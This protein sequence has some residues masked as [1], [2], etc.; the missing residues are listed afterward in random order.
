MTLWKWSQTPATNATADST[1]NWAEGQSPSSVNDSARAMMA[2]AAKYRDDHSGALVTGGTDTAYTVSSNQGFDTLA[3]LGGQSFKIKFDSTNGSAPTLNIDSLGAKAIQSADGTAIGTGII[4]ADSIWDVTYDNSIP[5]FILN[6]SGSYQPVDADLTAI[7][8]L[9]SA[10]DKVPYATGSGTWALA[11]FTSAGRALLDDADADAQLAT[12]GA[13]DLAKKDTI[14]SAS[15]IDTAVK[16]SLNPFGLQLFH[17]REVQNSGTAGSVKAGNASWEKMTI[18]TS[19][20]NE[21]T[22][23]SISSSVIS[24]PAGTYFIEAL[25]TVARDSDNAV[26]K[27]RLRNTTDNATT[28]VGQN[29][30]VSGSNQAAP[31]RGRFTLSG[32]KNLEIHAYGNGGGGSFPSALSSG[33]SEIYLDAMIWKIA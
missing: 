19:V 18:N 13:G 4:V 22:S 21:I 20:V 3:H 29:I 33:E 15:L 27:T 26:M 1:I 32:T 30:K 28:L 14:D 2:A 7:A 8:A 17:V 12:L 25:I 11:D 16:Q 6:G 31:L 24:L 9:T 10:A 5:A 23:A